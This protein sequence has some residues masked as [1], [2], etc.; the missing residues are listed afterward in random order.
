MPMVRWHI[1]AVPL[2][3]TSTPPA[4]RVRSGAAT[5]PADRP[6]DHRILPS[7][8]FDDGAGLVDQ[9]PTVQFI[10]SAHN[11]LGTRRRDNSSITAGDHGRVTTRSSPPMRRP[12]QW[13]DP[14]VGPGHL[15][16]MTYSAPTGLTLRPPDRMTSSA[17]TGRDLCAP[18]SAAGLLRR[19]ELAPLHNN[20]PDPDRA[21]PA[22]GSPL[23]L[24]ASGLPVKRW[25]QTG[26]TPVAC[27]PLLPW[28]T[29]N[30]TRWPSSRL[31]K[32][33]ASIPEWCTKTSLPPSS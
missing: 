31:R 33:L 13:T 16:W 26:R 14:R 21:C 2:R 32:P 30:C 22:S 28:L 24:R 7:K 17:F 8:A 4:S 29:S 19:V 3:T 25:D 5:I 15:I 27:R 1:Q 6:G 23:A 9:S 18:C 12:A 10:H 20:Q 11:P